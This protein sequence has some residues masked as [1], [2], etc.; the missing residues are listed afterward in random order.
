LYMTLLG[1]KVSSSEAEDISTKTVAT[2][3]VA[4]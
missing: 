4:P 3:L 1:L 2:L